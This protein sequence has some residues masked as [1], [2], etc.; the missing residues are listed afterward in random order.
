MRRIR[1]KAIS[2]LVI[3]ALLV[4]F[5][6][7]P[8]PA[9]AAAPPPPPLAT[10]HT[11]PARN[12]TGADRIETAVRISQDAWTSSVYVVVATSTDFPDALAG[13]PLA[14]ALGS[15]LLLTPPASLAPAVAA[16][17]SRLGA[18]RA[19][20]LGG[21]GA[22]SPAVV[23]GLVAAGISRQRIERVAGANRY[24]TARDIAARLQAAAG[25]AAGV[26]VASGRTYPDALAVAGYAARS[27]RPILLT[28]PDVLPPATK[29]AL[30]S[31][32]S[33]D[34]LIVGGTGAVS[35]AVA[36]Q[37]PEPQR[38]GGADRY[39]TAALIAEHA[40]STGALSYNELLVATGEAFPDA[41]AAGPYAAKRSATLI[42]TR[43]QSLPLATDDF[44]RAHSS[45]AARIT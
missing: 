43:S 20:V 33:T 41:L 19:V 23:D 38:I 18:T 21:T 15:P 3:F 30:A 32:E 25:P 22:L 4:P 12:L 5:I 29:Q 26:I 1:G 16:E 39:E 31:V 34:T 27:N 14:H 40:F 13:A 37:L 28:E 24:E 9:H 44:V 35:E 42:L 36:T 11:P 6:P 45:S 2:L 8:P 7:P 10:E 17:I